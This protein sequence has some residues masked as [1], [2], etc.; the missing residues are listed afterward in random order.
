VLGN[1]DLARGKYEPPADCWLHELIEVRSSPIEGRGLFCRQALPAG[2]VVARLG[3]RLVS[4]RDLERLIFDAER[5]PD[6]SYVDS[7]AVDGNTNLLIPP[8]EPIHFGNHSCDPTLWHIGPFTLAT[9]RDIAPGAELTIDYAT[10]TANPRVRFDCRCGSSRCRGTVTGEDWRRRDL[11]KRYGD[12]WVPTVLHRIAALTANP[13][14]RT[15]RARTPVELYPVEQL[16]STVT[17]VLDE[18]RGD[19]DQLVPALDIEHI[20]ATSLPDGLTKG[21]VDVNLR[22]D[23]GQFDHV[24]AMLSTR[25]G[26]A[27][28]QNWTATYASFSDDRRALPVGIQ[29]T[30]KGSNDDF[31]VMLRDRLRSDA[32]LRRE[33]NHLK[34]Q[35][36]SAGADVYWQAKNDFL[37]RLLG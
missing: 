35:N 10:Q 4:D 18:L 29:V 26:I 11:R 21:D 36:S 23:A 37:Q 2:T 12:H 7:I 32:D 16:A 3:G 17:S 13:T 28:P 15:R 27:Q 6:R 14:S 34:H 33:Y 9:R 1:R 31:L 24:V 20:G 25:F 8:G 19:L 5:D 22:V 30:V